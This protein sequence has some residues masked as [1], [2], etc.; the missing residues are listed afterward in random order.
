M[1]FVPPGISDLLLRRDLGN[2]AKMVILHAFVLDDELK[3]ETHLGLEFLQVEIPAPHFLD[4]GERLPNP[5]HGSVEGALDHNRF[6]QISFHGH[7]F[8]LSLQ[9]TYSS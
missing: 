2:L 9:L 6:C 7:V 4:I 5:P 3:L 1:S 8:S